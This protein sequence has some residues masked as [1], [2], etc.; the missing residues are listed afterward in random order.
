MASDRTITRRSGTW[1]Y[2]SSQ[3]IFTHTKEGKKEGAFWTH[4]Q[5]EAIVILTL[6]QSFV[7]NSERLLFC[8]IDFKLIV[9][10]RFFIWSTT[11][12]FFSEAA[13][14]AATTYQAKYEYKSHGNTDC[15]RKYPIKNAVVGDWTPGISQRPAFVVRAATAGSTVFVQLLVRHQI[16][17]NGRQTVGKVTT[18]SEIVLNFT[19]EDKSF[20]DFSFC[21]QDSSRVAPNCWAIFVCSRLEQADFAIFASGSDILT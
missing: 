12:P 3:H 4:S 6:L 5:I 18:K 7:I 11:A 9:L 17:N 1:E 20:A 16:S 21:D 15:Y 14:A 19:F 10:I 8:D 13:A 2:T